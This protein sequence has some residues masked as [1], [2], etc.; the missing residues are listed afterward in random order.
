MQAI[1][2]AL[3]VASSAVGAYGSLK[4]GRMQ[5]QG[6][7]A[8]AAA[9]EQEARLIDIQARQQSA[10][11][12]NQLNSALAAIEAQRSARNTSLT[13]P[14]ALATDRAVTREYGD[15]IDN[16]RLD[17]L[18]KARARRTDAQALRLGGQAA[19][20]AGYVGAAT[21]TF[22]AI[23]TLWNPKKSGS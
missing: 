9:A 8:Q 22:D 3:S 13:S 7:N 16:E 14:T 12:V 18:I 20:F 4:A 17:A 5:Q 21:H 23:N 2:V 6:A 15:A 10:I 11:R 19:R 1:P